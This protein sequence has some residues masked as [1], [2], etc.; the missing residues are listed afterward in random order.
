MY[1]K[2]CAVEEKSRVKDVISILGSV[3]GFVIPVHSKIVQAMRMYFERLVSWYGR[4]QLIPVYNEDNILNFYLSKEVKSTETN[5][6]NNSQQPRNE[7]RQ[8][9]CPR[10]SSEKSEHGSGPELV[11]TLHQLKRHVKMSR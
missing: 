1:T 8:S 7:C 5:I 9:R 3:S 11:I 6:V 2:F 4:K 10:K